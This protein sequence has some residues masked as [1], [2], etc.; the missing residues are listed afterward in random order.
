MVGY[1]ILGDEKKESSRRQTLSSRRAD[2]S[3]Y[4]KP[5]GGIPREAALVGKEAQVN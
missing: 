1:E 3:I 5:V 2:F 4:R